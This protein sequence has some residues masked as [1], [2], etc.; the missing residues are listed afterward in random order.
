MLPQ[1]GIVWVTHKSHQEWVVRSVVY[2]DNGSSS[3]GVISAQGCVDQWSAV[4]YVR[5]YFGNVMC[6]L[7]MDPY[8]FNYRSKWNIGEADDIE[9]EVGL[10]PD[11][12]LSIEMRSGPSRVAGHVNLLQIMNDIC[13][14]QEP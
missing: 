3:L 5:K 12:S 4:E 7:A 11:G 6:G 10:A 1:K 13:N 14:N 8:F 9:I 2:Y